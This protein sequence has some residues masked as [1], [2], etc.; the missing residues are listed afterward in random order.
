MPICEPFETTNIELTIGFAKLRDVMNRANHRFLEATNRR[1]TPEP[2]VVNN[3]THRIPLFYGPH[4]D[5][6]FIWSI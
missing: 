4:P 1:V 3:H 2:E 6:R 5:A